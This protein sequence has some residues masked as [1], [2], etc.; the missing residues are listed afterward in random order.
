MTKRTEEQVCHHKLKWGKPASTG[1][2]NWAMS[3]KTFLR[4]VVVCLLP[5]LPPDL[6]PPKSR[7]RRHRVRRWG[8]LRRLWRISLGQSSTSPNTLREATSQC[9]LCWK[10]RAR[11]RESKHFPLLFSTADPLSGFQPNCRRLIIALHRG[12]DEGKDGTVFRVITADQMFRS[13]EWTSP[14][15]KNKSNK[16]LIQE[17]IKNLSSGLPSPKK[18]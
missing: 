12:W 18:S 16:I 6:S 3:R 14:W 17:I 2:G 4:I 11:R 9:N 8:T 5:H 10:P 1:R 7:S 13:H 15:A